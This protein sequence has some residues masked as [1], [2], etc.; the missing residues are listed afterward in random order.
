MNGIPWSA[1]ELRWLR[2]LYPVT[3][4]A[5]ISSI[6]GRT[7]ASINAA[8]TT[9][10]LKKDPEYLKTVGIQKGS[11]V[12]AAHRFPKGHVP[13]NKGLRRPG[14]HAGRMRETQFR[15]GCRSGMAERLWKPV[16][17][18]HP[19]PEGY[20]RIKIRERDPRKNQNG[21]HPEIWPLLHHHIWKQH[22]GRIP[23]GHAI[24]FKDGNR[25]NC[26]IGNLECIPRAELARRNR[27][28]NRYP[29]ELA[30]AIH[31][32]GQLKRRIRNAEGRKEA[33]RG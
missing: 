16:G 12:G 18:I 22:H 30:E 10:G 9:Y 4:N 20:L 17:T 26:D 27:M 23:A 8:G 19:D 24:A 3:S 29:R 14:W 6:S 5:E 32:A 13:A 1:Q 7:V 33:R 15:R 25:A 11:Q 31:L 28:W 2:I 21:W